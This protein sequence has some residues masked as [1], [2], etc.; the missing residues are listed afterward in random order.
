MIPGAKLP[1]QTMIRLQMNKL[2]MT[3]NFFSADKRNEGEALDTSFAE[4]KRAAD[5]AS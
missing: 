1:T 3:T 5:D 4:H 2:Q